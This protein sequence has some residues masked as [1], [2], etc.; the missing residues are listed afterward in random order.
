MNTN[1]FNFVDRLVQLCCLKSNNSDSPPECQEAYDEGISV[2]SV[3][4]SLK[5]D[6]ED[7]K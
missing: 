5:E 3:Q 2:L 6:K 1:F 4:E 7:K